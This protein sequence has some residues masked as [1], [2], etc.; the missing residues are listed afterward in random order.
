MHCLLRKQEAVIRTKCKI[1]LSG[2]QSSPNN[3]VRV[4]PQIPRCRHW[5]DPG[6]NSMSI[7]VECLGFIF[8]SDV[9]LL[10]SSAVLYPTINSYE[11]PTVTRNELP[12]NTKVS[13]YVVQVIRNVFQ[14]CK[15]SRSSSFTA[16]PNGQLC[17]LNDALK[18]RNA[19][20]RVH[21]KSRGGTQRETEKPTCVNISFMLFQSILALESF[22]TALRF[23]DEPGI[24]FTRFLVL[25]KAV[26]KRK[27][28]CD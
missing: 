7:L 1:G 18:K 26:Q 24:S 17:P 12:Q 15:L 27:E 8:D 14:R 5:Q 2:Q 20:E 10:T 3:I 6:L 23:T 19:C 11:I 13:N 25:F 16:I 4:I 22:A 28:H 21:P 9:W